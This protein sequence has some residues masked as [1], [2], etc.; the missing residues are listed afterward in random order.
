MSRPKRQRTV[1]VTIR[2]RASGWVMCTGI[3]VERQR[4]TLHPSPPVILIQDA[5]ASHA[6]AM[7]VPWDRLDARALQLGQLLQ[8]R[9]F[10][11]VNR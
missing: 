5:S 4:I 8:R 3:R 10:D 9:W 2:D 11:E 1:H 6:M 7:T